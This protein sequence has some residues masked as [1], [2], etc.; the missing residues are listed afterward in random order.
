MEVVVGD[1]VI[2]SKF[3]GTEFKVGDEELL[4]LGSHDI[5]AKLA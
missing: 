2:F 5:L 3:G 1:Q 4:V